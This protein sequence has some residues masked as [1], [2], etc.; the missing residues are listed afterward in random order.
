MSPD[1][2]MDQLGRILDSETFSKAPVLRRFFSF[3]SSGRFKGRT[4]EL[5]EYALGVDVFDRGSDFDPRTDTIVRVQARRLR[6]KLAEYYDGP[7]RA[8]IGSSSSCRK[9]PTLLRSD[10]SPRGSSRRRHSTARRCSRR[11]GAAV[12]RRF[13]CRRRALRLIGRD[14]DLAT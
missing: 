1:E 3:W 4:D 13:R 2:A 14:D 5:K 11:T 9:G 12:P 8:P 10:P 7:G 6:A